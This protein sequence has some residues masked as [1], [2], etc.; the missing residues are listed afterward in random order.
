MPMLLNLYV[1]VGDGGNFDK[2]VMNEAAVY[3]AKN[4]PPQAGGPK[5]ANSIMTKWKVA[6]KL[7]EYI[8]QAKQ[9]RYPGTSGWTYTDELGFNVMDDDR[10]AWKN[11]AKTHQHFKPFATCGWI[12]FKTVD[13]II[14]SLAPFRPLSAVLD[15]SQ[16][17]YGESQ[18]PNL[19]IPTLP[20]QPSQSTVA[21]DVPA[22]V[23]ATPASA[24]KGMPSDDVEAPWSNKHTRTTGPESILALGRSVE[25]IR[26]VMA[27][28][29]APQKSSAMSPT[30]KVEVARKIALDNMKN[31]YLSSEE[32]TRLNI[33]FVW[34]TTAADAYIANDDTFLRV[35]TALY[36]G[37]DNAQ[38]TSAH[39]LSKLSLEDCL[40]TLYLRLLC[41]EN[42]NSH[43][44]RELQ[45]T[46]ST[47]TTVWEYCTQNWKP[48]KQQQPITS[49]NNLVDIAET[50]VHDHSKRLNLQLYQTDPMVK[51]QVFAGVKAKQLLTAFGDKVVKK[52]H[53][54][55]IPNMLPIEILACLALMRKITLLLMTDEAQRAHGGD[56]G[57]WWEKEIV[58]EDD[59]KY[60][61]QGAESSARTRSDTNAA[62]SAATT[63]GFS[64]DDDDDENSCDGREVN[65][66][67]LDNLAAL[68][69]GLESTA[70]LLVV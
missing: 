58:A 16:S 61:R 8:L 45:V 46:Q 67:E 9:K 4:W 66:S 40:I 27:A 11:F 31:G 44:H 70:H 55:T 19:V 35:D 15:W 5:T 3:M 34:N 42:Q 24:L 25:G 33:L 38:C 49:Y 50:Y 56:Y 7:H 69:M 30:K 51:S 37:L 59:A 63:D 2:T 47:I 1:L 68:G 64:D 60:V 21:H 20:P 54:P 10:E 14:P 13:E 23:P 57:F 17:N 65:L 22:T 26:K 62:M 6:H 29:F 43:I 52:Y 32:R 48:S 39:D 53:L 36:H 41:A 18:P 28:V 12:H